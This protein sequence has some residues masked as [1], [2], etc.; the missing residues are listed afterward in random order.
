MKDP[1]VAT[2]KSVAGLRPTL[3]KRSVTTLLWVLG[4]AAPIFAAQMTAIGTAVVTG[5][6]S[7]LNLATC[8]GSLV[9]SLLL[10]VPFAAMVLFLVLFACTR[11]KGET[12]RLRRAE[13]KEDLWMAAAY[14]CV[15]Y[16]VTPAITERLPQTHG[17]MRWL[18][19]STLEWSDGHFHSL[20]TPQLTYWLERRPREPQITLLVRDNGGGYM[21]EAGRLFA[22]F[23]DHGITHVH[24]EG[25]CAS[26]CTQLFAQATSR[27]MADD[28]VLK[29]HAVYND[30]KFTESGYAHYRALTEPAGFHPSI[31]ERSRDLPADEYLA[32]TR[33]EI[34]ACA[35]DGSTSCVQLHERPSSTPSLATGNEEAQ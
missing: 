21:A 33:D 28:A 18:D 4:P 7:W 16:S 5:N 1:Q 23:D 25:I 35:P 13:L 11:G 9:V 20:L 24:I 3:V 30:R 17:K 29:F 6:Y 31:F 2:T 12:S 27:S 22:A 26:A 10:W 34:I 32:V 14:F 19:A 8:I 15:M